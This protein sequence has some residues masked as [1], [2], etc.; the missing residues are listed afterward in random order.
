MIDELSAMTAYGDKDIIRAFEPLISTA[1]TQF[2]SV[3]GRVVGAT[4]E[5]TKDVIP[6]RGLFPTKIALRLDQASY[7]DMCLGEGAR[8]MGAFADKI[9]AYLPG[10]AYVKQDGRREPL[11][12]RAPYNTDADIAELVEFCTTRDA[13]VIPLHRTTAAD[14]VEH[15]RDQPHWSEIDFEA[16]EDD[17]DEIDEISYFEGE[18]DTSA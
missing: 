14:H 7:V 6:M 11:R 3:G 5:P 9:P 12:S 15:T 8:D 1:L 10:V 16:L 17:S 18:E 13:T 2:R 4:Q